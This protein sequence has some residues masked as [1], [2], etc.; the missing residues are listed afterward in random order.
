MTVGKVGSPGQGGES[1][2]QSLRQPEGRESTG[3][4]QEEL[5]G[6]R[7]HDNDDS[8]SQAEPRRL[9]LRENCQAADSETLG[10]NVDSDRAQPGARASRGSALDPHAF[11]ASA[12]STGTEKDI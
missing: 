5:S 3:K 11:C 10:T 1:R 12:M 9:G 8:E 2:G 7:D 6:L 4:A